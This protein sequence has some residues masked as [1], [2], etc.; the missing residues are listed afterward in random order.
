MDDHALTPR[1]GY[2]SGG[3]DSVEQVC[4][5]LNPGATRIFEELRRDAIVARCFVILKASQAVTHFVEREFDPQP[6][7]IVPRVCLLSCQRCMC[8]SQ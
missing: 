8:A 6:E 1:G 3:N 2:A 4:K 7:G 5:H